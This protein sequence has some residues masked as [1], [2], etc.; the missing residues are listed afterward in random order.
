MSS[1]N[2]LGNNAHRFC[3]APMLDWTDRH[4]R[5][6]LRLITQR[7]LLY[8]EMITT[9]ALIHGDRDR[10]LSFNE[11]EHPVAVQLGGSDPSELAQCAEIVQE[12]GYDELNLNVGCPSDRVQS[13]R[14]GAC[15]MAEPKLV[16]EGVKAMRK[17]CDIPVTVK[18]R[19]GIDQHDS[20]E[21]LREFIETV[22][23]GGCD[24]FIVHARIALLK[25]LSPKEN[26]DIP[27]LNYPRVKALKSAYPELNF[28]I[29]G[30]IKTLEQAQEL[31]EELDGVMVGREAYHN[32]WVLKDVDTLFYGLMPREGLSR[33]D[34]MRQFMP[35]IAEELTT[36]T[37]LQHIS[38]HILGLFHGV[39]GGKAFRRHISENAYKPGSGLS[40]IEDALALVN[41]F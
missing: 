5:Y 31:A 33:K 30:G 13:G 1:Q 11:F 25:G 3:V 23:A 39:H 17:A 15:L 32:P 9:G 35:Y 34:I 12:A 26:R 41:E 24:T 7:A 14:F 38:R 4:E 21:F 22:A 19:I 18:C 10:H 40:V 27:P 28:I 36:G 6:F 29:N 20:E 37:P 16:A 8:T 2:S